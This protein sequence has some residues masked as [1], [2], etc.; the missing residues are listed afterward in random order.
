MVFTRAGDRAQVKPLAEDGNLIVEEGAVFVRGDSNGDGKVDISDAIYL[1]SYLFRGGPAV[2]CRA[3]Q[4]VS[5][6]LRATPAPDST[7]RRRSER[8]TIRL[9]RPRDVVEN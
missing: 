1:L 4:P 9:A 8:Q 5:R 7:S 3:V 2:G 6:H